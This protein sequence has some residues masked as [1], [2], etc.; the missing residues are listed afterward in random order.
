MM[1]AEAYKILLGVLFMAGWWLFFVEY[2]RYRVDLFR[3]RI[4]VARDKMFHDAMN[5][6]ISF[7][8]PAYGMTRIT[9]NGMLRFAHELNFL[10]LILVAISYKLFSGRGATE[11][12]RS[13]FSE[14][15]K[16][17][18]FEEKKVVVNTMVEAHWAILDHI[19]HTSPLFVWWLIPLKYV[20][21]AFNSL[22]TALH[23]VLSGKKARR[24]WSIFDASANVMG[25]DDPA[26]C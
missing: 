1:P 10:Q 26:Y 16:D 14:A 4:F 11:R 17:L 20:L 7:D 21:M 8:S 22:K 3:Y 2:H 12:Y 6:K 9:L 13:K 15:I 19:A 18:N 5:G 24:S 23:K 25:C